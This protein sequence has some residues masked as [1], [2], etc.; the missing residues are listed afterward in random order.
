MTDWLMSNIWW[1]PSAVVLVVA[2]VQ[3]YWPNWRQR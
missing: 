3:G 2:T 1:I